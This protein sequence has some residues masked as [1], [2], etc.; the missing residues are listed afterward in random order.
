MKITISQKGIL[1]LAP[2]AIRGQQ[3]WCPNCGQLVRIC[4]GKAKKAYFAH[5][6]DRQHGQG[7]TNEHQVGKIQMLKW[8]KRRGWQGELEHYYPQIKQRADILLKRSTQQVIIEFQCSNLDLKRLVER[9]QGY[10]QIGIKPI[11]ILGSPY[12]HRLRANR[13]AQFT[14]LDH[15]KP[16]IYFWDYQ[17][18]E[19][20]KMAGWISAKA[21]I[22]PQQVSQDVYRSQFSNGKNQTV[23]QIVTQVYQAGHELSTSP[24]VAHCRETNWPFLAE[25]LFFW[26]LRQLLWIERFELGKTWLLRE[27]LRGVDQFSAWLPLP[28]LTAQQRQQVHQ[29]LIWAWTKQL[30]TARIL[31]QDQ[32]RIIY[33]HPPVWFPNYEAKLRALRRIK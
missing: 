21:K 25:P 1:T 28:C 16:T 33:W 4:R 20:I 19:L 31:K 2:N 15:Q 9:N 26:H 32:H 10:A 11:W 18:A 7:E 5:Q 22:N 29:Q 14:Y 30:L 6:N 23:R 12:R 24:L 13:Q 3:Y 8:A 17:K 27:W